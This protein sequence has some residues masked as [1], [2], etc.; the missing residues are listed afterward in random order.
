MPQNI[1]SFVY[2]HAVIQR[3]KKQEKV[4]KRRSTASWTPFIK[5]HDTCKGN[6]GTYL[7]REVNN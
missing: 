7:K 6:F 2:I 4:I 1:E 5:H 3:Q